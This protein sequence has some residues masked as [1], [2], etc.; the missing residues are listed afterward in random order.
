MK[1]Q[2]QTIKDDWIK[3]MHVQRQVWQLTTTVVHVAVLKMLHLSCLH[4]A[5]FHFQETQK[6][7][8]A[9]GQSK[10]LTVAWIPQIVLA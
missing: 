6:P 3:D 4:G 10:C 7:F 8:R 2:Q 9:D 5:L 1:L